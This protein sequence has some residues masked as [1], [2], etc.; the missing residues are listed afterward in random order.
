MVRME[1]A[2]NTS[3]PP[4]V[5]RAFS[6]EMLTV[7]MPSRLMKIREGVSYFITYELDNFHLDRDLNA[8]DV[9]EKL[10]CQGLQ[11]IETSS[12]QLRLTTLYKHPWCIQF[13]VLQI[14]PTGFLPRQS[15]VRDLILFSVNPLSAAANYLNCLSKLFQTS[16]LETPTF[17]ASLSFNLA[18]ARLIY[19][20]VQG[21][22]E[23]PY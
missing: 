21:T 6:T 17:H 15:Y 10:L 5:L 1:A 3:L 7:E 14:Q 16:L 23:T 18:L 13:E 11:D 19:T 2:K 20:L 9:I 22:M 8:W 12:F 4:L